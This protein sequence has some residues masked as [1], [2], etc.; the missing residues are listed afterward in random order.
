MYSKY[1]E[2]CELRDAGLRQKANQAAQDFVAEYRANPDPGFITEICESATHKINFHIWSG[3]VWPFYV[4]DR[5]NPIAIKY[6]IQTIQNLYS[7]KTAHK[8]VDGVTEWQLLDQYLDAVPKDKWATDR[9]KVVLSDW[10]AH[11]IHEW[12]SGVLYEN[13]GATIHE[14][15]KILQ[16]IEELR[17]IDDRSDYEALCLDVEQKTKEYLEQLQ[18]DN[19][20]SI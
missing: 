10:L 6:L 4:E 17:S 5:T 9:K 2:F 3:V 1:L 13:D 7:D 16:E 20:S 12:P 11:V 15:Q 14:C 19:S 18:E 8:S